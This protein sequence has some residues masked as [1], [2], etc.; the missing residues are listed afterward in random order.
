[1]RDEKKT[2][3]EWF[4]T[5]VYS[6]LQEFEDTTGVEVHNIE[7]ERI[8]IER[9]GLSVLPETKLCKWILTLK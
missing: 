3:K 2:P 4:L 6:A 7:I 8:E 5:K 1:M 9:V